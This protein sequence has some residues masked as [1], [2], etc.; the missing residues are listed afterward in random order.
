LLTR[1]LQWLFVL[2][3]NTK[4]GNMKRVKICPDMCQI[5]KIDARDALY[6]QQNALDSEVAL[7]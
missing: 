5:I 7:G 4:L 3:A 1:Q 6:F 2:A